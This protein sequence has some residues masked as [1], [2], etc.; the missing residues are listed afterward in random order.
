MY[1]DRSFFFN[2][3]FLCCY[4]VLKIFRNFFGDKYKTFKGF[5]SLNLIKK[6]KFTSLSLYLY[7]CINNKSKNDPDFIIPI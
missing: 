1:V 5:L 3:N 7:T 2:H 6:N 4:N